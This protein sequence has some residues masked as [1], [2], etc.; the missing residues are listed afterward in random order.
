MDWS[1]KLISF[2]SELRNLLNTKGSFFKALI[3]L[4]T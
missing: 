2:R 4:K 1:R 3:T